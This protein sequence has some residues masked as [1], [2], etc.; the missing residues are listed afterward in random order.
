MPRNVGHLP[1]FSQVCYQGD[2]LEVRKLG[3][4]LV[5][6]WVTDISGRGLTCY[7]TALALGKSKFQLENN[8]FLIY[9]NSY[10]CY[11]FVFEEGKET[12]EEHT[13]AYMEISIKY[14]CF[15]R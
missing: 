3:I 1:L 8:C 2:R 7:A 14:L 12:A 13:F 6:K 5:P 15:A 4:E 9:S 11:F 10:F